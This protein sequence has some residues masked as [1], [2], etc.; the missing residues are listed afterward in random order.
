MSLTV[1][2]QSRAF[3]NELQTLPVQFKVGA[4]SWSVFG[5]PK[6][7]EIQVEGDENDLWEMIERLRCPITIWSDNGD[8]VWWGF[9]AEVELQLPAWTVGVNIDSMYNRIAVA[10][11][12]AADNGETGAR[13][14]TSWLEDAD[15]VAEYGR[16]EL[17]YTSSGSSLAHAE[18]ARA[19]LLAQKKF[20]IPT[21]ERADNGK[22]GV[23]L[24]CR[25]WYSILNWRYY[26]ESAGL[27]MYSTSGPGDQAVGTQSAIVNEAAGASVGIDGQIANYTAA[28]ISFD[29]ATQRI[30]DSAN[31]LAIFLDGTT[32]RIKGSV[33][34]DG[35]YTITDGAN[36][37]YIAVAGSAIVN[38]TAGASVGIDGQ[39]AN[40]TAATISFDA[41][42]QR[43]ND[44]ANGLADFLDDTTIRVEG[45]VSNNGSYIVL[46]GGNAGFIAVEAANERI[47]QGFQ[48][49][50][51]WT[52]KTV[53]INIKAVETVTDNVDV[54][55]CADASGA[56]GTVLG[57]GAITGSTVPAD[58]V[59]M[60][61]NLTTPV[62]LDAGTP[63]WL[64]VKR[65][66][67]LDA[68]NYFVLEVN[69]DLGYSAG[70]LRLYTGAA[71]VARVPDA[72]LNFK[73]SSTED[74]AIQ[75]KNIVTAAGEFI[76][77]VD[78]DCYSGLP[79]SQF[80]DG[81]GLALYEVEEMLKMG[82]SNFRRM[83]ATVDIN[84]RV[85]I[86][87]EPTNDNPYLISKKGELRDALDNPVR[88]EQ[89]PV[90]VYARLKDV[91]PGS[92]DTSKLA[93]PSLMFVDEAEYTP[94]TG[95]LMVQPRG[96]ES[97]WD[98]G[99]PI[100]G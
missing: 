46:A 40:Y 98:I 69:E 100:D 50:K 95:K 28:T 64:V 62:S 34:N 51:A 82:T 7:A 85:R 52:V 90:G 73:L 42:T 39:I 19:M 67:A 32:I 79:I 60:V 15:S 91:I 77:A 27:E 99:R 61:I 53:E 11:T 87:E 74:T 2:I 21:I 93:D 78:L 13:E 22:I 3:S 47:G 57:S 35:T 88:A 29:A 70:A 58:Y 59:W 26:A 56:P 6:S 33:S 49:S 14:T 4:Y 54:Q 81:D 44:S 18:A 97:P 31:G 96:M 71:W 66:G 86:Y 80:R 12:T 30:N 92:L 68:V 89:C 63:Y 17:L 43:I 1:S 75:I 41:A 20:P 76:T 94:D 23:T 45:S 48:L 38:E 16:K 37:G 84:R 8:A 36:A 24:R 83:L 72:D 5:G 65:S 9:V 55:I 25:G 10:Y